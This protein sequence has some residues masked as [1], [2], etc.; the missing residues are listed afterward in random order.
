VPFIGCDCPVCTSPDPR[1]QRL[2]CSL[3]LRDGDRNVLLDCGPD[4]RQQALRAGLRSLDAVVLTH[5]HAD[6]IFGL[7][8]LR[9]MIIRR[10]SRRMPIYGEDEVL[11]AVRR[12]YNYAFGEHDSGSFRPRFELQRIASVSEPLDIAGFPLLPIRV[13]H[14]DVATRFRIATSRM[15]PTPEHPHRVRSALRGLDTLI[16]GSSDARAPHAPQHRSS[17]GH[18]RRTAAASGVPHPP[19]P[20]NRLRRV[21]SGAAERGGAGVRWVDGRDRL[22]AKGYCPQPPGRVGAAPAGAGTMPMV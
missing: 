1:N 2:R 14:S 21:F 3:L 15:S 17:P 13:L 6:H 9:L 16:R 11:D 12:I 18:H 8:D 19:D 7:D 20:R 5:Q 22:T 4:F 10:E